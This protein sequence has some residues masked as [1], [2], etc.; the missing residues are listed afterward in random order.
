MKIL[1]IIG[2]GF[3]IHHGL[4]T[5]YTDFYQYVSANNVELETQLENY[6]N[7]QVDKNYLWKSFESDLCHFDFKSFYDTYDHTDVL[8]DNFK[9]SE[10]FGL[11]DEISAEADDLVQ[12]VR[13]EFL[14]WIES[15][16][17]PDIE[18]LRDKIIHLREGS[19]FMNFNYTDTLEEIYG[20]SKNDILY[21]HNN[22]N[23]MSGELIFGHAENKEHNPKPD[24]F[25][26]DG[27][28]NRTMFT[29]AEDAARSPFYAFQKDTSA[30][31]A[32]HE[33]FFNNLK[34]VE[35]VIVLGHSLGKV[36]WPYFQKLAKV[37]KHANWRISYYSASE[38]QN[39]RAAATEM[40][41][42]VKPNISI[43]RID[44]LLIK[45]AG[46]TAFLS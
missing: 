24:D 3:D 11:E 10:R 41:T 22:A 25:D 42:K 12:T 37:A 13:S 14:N 30:A 23:D 16:E 1:Y 29:D 34:D 19:T 40:L 44:D 39:M 7:F 20:V 8:S 36:D 17:Y 18:S 6:F 4:K 26:D 21:L 5:K 27:Y 38:K 28:S 35:E 9:P 33:D 31:L 46:G 45:H 2:N 15:V 32:Q 43:F